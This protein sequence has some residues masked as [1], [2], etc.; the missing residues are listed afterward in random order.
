MKLYYST[1]SPYSRKVRLFIIEKS[2]ESQVE[3]I[4]VNPFLDETASSDNKALMTANPLSKVPTLVIDNGEAVFDSTVICHFLA[5][6]SEPSILIP[7]EKKQRTEVLRWE[8]TV[9]GLTNA[10]YNLVMERKRPV[11]E[12]S[13]KWMSTWSADILRTLDYIEKHIDEIGSNVSLA[14]LALAS[15]ISYLDFRLPTILYE[16]GCPQIAVCP[17]VLTWYEMFKTRPSMQATQLRELTS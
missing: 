10:A 11:N 2:L 3:E 17:N 8:A 9:T 1:T 16:S 6:L 13:S 4:I 7:V 14:H 15:A 12:Q 5:D